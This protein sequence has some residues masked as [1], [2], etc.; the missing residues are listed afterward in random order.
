M[1][2]DLAISLSRAERL[3]RRTRDIDTIE[4]CDAVLKLASLNLSTVD[5]LK[6]RRTDYWRKYKRFV[7]ACSAGPR[8]PRG[9]PRKTTIASPTA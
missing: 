1:H 3:R 2:P 6:P 9:R 4:L 8:K 7:R 5:T